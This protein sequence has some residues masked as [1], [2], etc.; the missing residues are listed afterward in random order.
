MVM[1]RRPYQIE[2]LIINLLVWAIVIVGV[3]S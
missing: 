1:T 2:M 3:M